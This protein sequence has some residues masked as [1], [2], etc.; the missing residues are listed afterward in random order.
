MKTRL[1]SP[2]PRIH[3]IVQGRYVHFTLPAAL[4]FTFA[5]PSC[6]PQLPLVPS[7]RFPLLTDRETFCSAAQKRLAAGKRFCSAGEGV[8]QQENVL[9]RRVGCLQ[10]RGLKRLLCRRE[11]YILQQETLSSVA[12]KTFVLQH[13]I[14]NNR[15]LSEMFI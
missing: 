1:L 10:C 6:P 9:W 14:F 15:E 3:R 8:Q 2:S 13:G 7:T 4:L 11:T 12:E 5:S